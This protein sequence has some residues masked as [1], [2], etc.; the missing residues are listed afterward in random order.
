MAAASR[1]APLRIADLPPATR[2]ASAALAATFPPVPDEVVRRIEP[3]VVPVLR[4]MAA[5]Q[6]RGDA[7]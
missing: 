5:Q 4:Q 1:P 3:V 7:A 6:Q 2:A